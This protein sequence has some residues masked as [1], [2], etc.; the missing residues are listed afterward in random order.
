MKNL[1][2]S[3]CCSSSLIVL[4]LRDPCQTT[5]LHAHVHVYYQS[6][7]QM[8]QKENLSS[9]F[10]RRGTVPFALMTPQ[11]WV[12]AVSFRARRRFVPVK[13]GVSCPHI[14]QQ[15]AVLPKPCLCSESKIKGGRTTDFPLA[16]V[17]S[18]LHFKM[19]LNGLAFI[20]YHEA[21]FYM[22]VG[23]RY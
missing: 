20:R 17:H 4:S 6:V 18:P 14:Q 9:T 23:I 10:K 19:W 8:K 2:S 22:W 16:A 21:F 3:P 11:T 7:Q 12:L 13:S 15:H 1:L 5:T